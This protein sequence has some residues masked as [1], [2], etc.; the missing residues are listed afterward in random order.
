MVA[1]RAHN[2]KVVGSNP[3]S[4]TIRNLGHPSGWGFSFLQANDRRVL[5][6]L[7]ATAPLRSQGQTRVF[8]CGKTI[9]SAAPTVADEGQQG[10][11][12]RS[13]KSSRRTAR[14]FWLAPARGRLFKS[15][16]P[17]HKRVLII[18]VLRTFSFCMIFYLLSF[19]RTGLV[20]A[21]CEHQTFY[22]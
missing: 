13:E 16:F 1:R 10:M 15:S 3:A 21:I 17:G 18:P 4:A 6:R 7:P 19:I 11:A 12:Q 9:H 14:G 20:F 2:P 22:F 8:A 5:D